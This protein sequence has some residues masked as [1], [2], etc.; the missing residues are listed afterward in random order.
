MMKKRPDM[1]LALAAA[2]LALALVAGPAP[3]VSLFLDAWG[4]SYGNWTAA[5]VA[6]ANLGMVTED[7]TA[8][9]DGYLGPGYGGQGYDV[10]A[11][12]IGLDENFLY[13]A[14]VTGFPL[15]GRYD[16]NMGETY[17]PGDLAVDIGSD[18]T[19]DLAVDVDA[20]GLVRSQG[21]TWE[22]PAIQG[23]PAWGGVMDPLRVTAWSHTDPVAGFRYGSW[24]GRY[25]IEA[26]LDRSV[27][28][29]SGSYTLH[30]TMGC[31]NDGLDV[32]VNPVPEPT[33]LILLGTGLGLLGLVVRRRRS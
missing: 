14:I 18:G 33:A 25:A 4:I 5:G 9:G 24:S 3:A 27:V 11:A 1:A 30:W 16:G 12:Y 10:E 26:I 22:N 31:G 17:L 8:G 28:P 2:G 13:L 23:N 15:S 21:L 19:Y 32:M 20:G 29:G 7:W 6:P